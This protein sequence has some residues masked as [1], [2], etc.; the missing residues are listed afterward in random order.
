MIRKL[1]PSFLIR[2]LANRIISKKKI[3]AII[4][5][6]FGHRLLAYLLFLSVEKGRWAKD[7][8]SVLCIK[9]DLFSKDI[10]ELRKLARSLN[11]LV[12]GTPQLAYTQSAWIPKELRHQTF[13]QKYFTEP[14]QN[15]WKESQLFSERF[16][17]LVMSKLNVKVVLSANIDYWQDEGMRCSCRTF[18]IPFLVLSKENCTIPKDSNRLVKYYKE[19]NFKFHGDGIAVFNQNMKNVLIKSGVCK[20]R[21]IYV[22]GAPRLDAWRNIKLDKCYQDTIVLLPYGMDYGLK[23]DK[24][25]K[26]VLNVFLSFAKKH[27]GSTIN[28][29]V[30]CKN[31]KYKQDL[32]KKIIK[33]DLKYINLTVDKPL[34]ELFP[35]SQLIIGY[36]SLALIEALLSRAVIAIPQWGEIGDDTEA[37]QFDPKDK[38]CSGI[39]EF[40]KSRNDME[41]LLEKIINNPHSYVDMKERINLLKRYF[42]YNPYKTNSEYVED[43]VLSYIN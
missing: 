4:Y 29:V 19:T 21:E 32:E 14:Y 41:K 42:F 6:L 20:S 2:S 27:R 39:I 34:Y 31:N 35:R 5:R 11:W 36:N 18:S 17:K 1:H 7:R 26:D 12:I 23:S 25:F 13:F 24:N 3:C 40:V 16:L 22:T 37:Q 38:A 9:R 10:V 43:F 15:K 28:F 33:K 30:K 8:I